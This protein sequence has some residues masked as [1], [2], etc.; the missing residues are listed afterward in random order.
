[1]KCLID[2]RK[3]CVDHKSKMETDTN[4]GMVRNFFF[5]QRIKR[6]R[7]CKWKNLCGVTEVNNNSE[8]PTHQLSP[9]CLQ[10]SL[11]QHSTLN[12]LYR[13]PKHLPLVR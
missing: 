10:S 13:H 4:R 7:Y 11:A 6:I 8:F 12:S 9:M 2:H 5:L 1:M 3:L